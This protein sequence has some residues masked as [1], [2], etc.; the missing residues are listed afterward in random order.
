MDDS[1]TGFIRNQE[2]HHLSYSDLSAQLTVQQQDLCQGCH[3]I[4]FLN[5]RAQ[6]VRE[7]AVNITNSWSVAFPTDK[8]PTLYIQQRAAIYLLMSWC[9]PVGISNSY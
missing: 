7:N 2:R 9:Y 1:S 6:G 5:T 4:H 8:C 3:P